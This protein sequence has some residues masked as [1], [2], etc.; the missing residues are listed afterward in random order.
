MRLYILGDKR[1]QN[2]STVVQDGQLNTLFN[3]EFQWEICH[4]SPRRVQEDNL[5]LT[6]GDLKK[7]STHKF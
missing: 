3:F 4:K 2:F 5:K 6:L 7:N 1:L